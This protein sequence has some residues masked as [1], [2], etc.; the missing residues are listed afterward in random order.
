M[1]SRIFKWKN[2]FASLVFSAA[3]T[4]LASFSPALCAQT[5]PDQLS[6][7]QTGAESTVNQ[8]SP[9]PDI[10][11]GTATPSSSANADDSGDTGQTSLT[12][13]QIIAIARGNPEV[14]L[15]LKSYLAASLQARGVLT[16][17]DSISD[18]Q[19]YS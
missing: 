10:G 12:A 4:C 3:I 17:A 9:R 6:S 5:A 7:S 19:V 15:E 8:E 2:P 13:P 11:T 16:Q 18:E 1:T 14:M